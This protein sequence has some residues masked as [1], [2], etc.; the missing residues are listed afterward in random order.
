MPVFNREQC[1]LDAV[2]SLKK[3][4]FHNWELIIIDDGSND[5]TFKVCSEAAEKDD[6]IH[7]VHQHN[8]GVSAARNVGLKQ[9]E[10]EYILFLDSDDL[11]EL[12]ALSVLDKSIHDSSKADLICFG[13]SRS[14]GSKWQPDSSLC[15]HILSAETIERCF[16]PDHLNI[17]PHTK[18]FLQPFVW[19]KCFKKSVIEKADAQFDEKK[20]TWEDGGF[21]IK[22]LANA[23]SIYLI[24]ERL[25]RAG[26][27][28][29]NDHLGAHYDS[30][31]L[32]NFIRTCEEYEHLYKDRFQFDQPYTSMHN[33]ELLCF[34][35]Q[36]LRSHSSFDESVYTAFH[37]PLVHR[38][39]RRAGVHSPQSALIKAA[40]LTKNKW[41]LR[42]ALADDTH[43]FRRLI[44]HIKK[45]A[46]GTNAHV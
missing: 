19:N 4:C 32:N 15:N 25:Y 34:I 18:Y 44:R 3:Q 24:R 36:R 10:G 11:L 21:F 13:Y 39:T 41:L 14:S 22:C 42:Q 16:L 2:N 46:K 38:W 12:N 20:K 27:S 33:L 40:F 8:K 29:L 31:V 43:F 7:V 17:V 45:S 28:G 23:D 1:V 37:D 30:E 5:G 35:L 9:A 6:R 26:D